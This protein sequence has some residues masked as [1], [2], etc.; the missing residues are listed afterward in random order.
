MDNK[1]AALELLGQIAGGGL[2]G[3]VDVE[4]SQTMPLGLPVGALAGFAIAAGG[5]AMSSGKNAKLGGH[6]LNVGGGMLA[7]ESGIAV[8]N[9]VLKAKAAAPATPGATTVAG[10]IGG[11][12]TPSAASF[13]TQTPPAERAITADMLRQHITRARAHAAGAR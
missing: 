3:L 13:V 6:L 9:R 4:T 12:R 2:A 10:T 7:Y 11:M 8:A 1:A 5:F